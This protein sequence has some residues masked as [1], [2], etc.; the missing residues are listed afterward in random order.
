MEKLEPQIEAKQLGPRFYW[1]FSF[2][3]ALNLLCGPIELA[4]T[5]QNQIS[6]K[7]YLTYEKDTTK[8]KCCNDFF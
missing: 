5:T 4:F 7:K 8:I 1:S 6:S 3:A 2:V